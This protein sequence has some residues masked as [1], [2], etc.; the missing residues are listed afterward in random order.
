MKISREIKLEYEKIFKHKGQE[1]FYQYI[2]WSGTVL[3]KDGKFPDVI[4]LDQSEGFFSAFR[5]TGN[6]N[7]FTIG[8]ILRRAAHKLYRERL[9]TIGSVPNNRFLHMIKCQ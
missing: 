7:Y 5:Q 9:L 4:F 1:A 2:L 3:K 8:Q 6:E